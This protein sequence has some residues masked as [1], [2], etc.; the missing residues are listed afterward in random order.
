MVKRKL[1]IKMVPEQT[2][3]FILGMNIRNV[4]ETCRQTLTLLADAFLVLNQ[5]VDERLKTVLA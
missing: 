5:L 4:Y 3:K 2:S 1:T